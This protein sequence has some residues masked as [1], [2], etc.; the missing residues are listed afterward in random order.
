MGSFFLEGGFLD[1]L[2]T[3]FLSFQISLLLVR[4]PGVILGFRFR[5]KRLDLP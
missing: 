5:E 1:Y 2:M 3:Y 4:V